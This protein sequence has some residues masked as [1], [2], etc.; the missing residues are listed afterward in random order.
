MF[1]W[2]EVLLGIS[3]TFGE[4][5][6]GRG[7]FLICIQLLYQNNT[8]FGMENDESC[9]E[10]PHVWMR[11]IIDCITAKCFWHAGKPTLCPHFIL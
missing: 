5:G 7:G 9:I 10:L 11:E 6:F 1:V 4:L 8:Y 2:E 3:I